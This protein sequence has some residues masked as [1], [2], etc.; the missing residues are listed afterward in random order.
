MKDQFVESLLDY[1]VD[2]PV[3]AHHEL[4]IRA[5]LGPLLGDA[6]GAPRGDAPNPAASAPSPAGTAPATPGELGRWL[7]IVGVAVGAGIGGFAAGRATAPPSKAFAPTVLLPAKPT[8]TES[9]P[10]VPTVAMT[11]AVATPAEAAAPAH[12]AKS[13]NTRS[14]ASRAGEGPADSFD[15]EQSLLERARSALIRHDGAA[16]AQALDECEL[17][18]AQS[19]HAEERDY[20]RIQVLRELGNVGQTR[21]HARAFLAKYPT[22]LLKGRVESLAQ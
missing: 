5:G 3:P 6:P 9:V 22:S 17:H 11:S 2:E 7:A 13:A 15:R 20:L 21:L 8:T 18:F 1:D 10:P 14:S 12:T 16:A 4:R 19:T